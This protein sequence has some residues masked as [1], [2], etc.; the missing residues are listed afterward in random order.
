MEISQK[1]FKKL[2]ELVG[3]L[4]ST[5]KSSAGKINQYSAK[6]DKTIERIAALEAMAKKLLK[7]RAAGG[8]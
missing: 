8:N 2:V 4:N 5:V 6:L 7:A 1:E 3:Q